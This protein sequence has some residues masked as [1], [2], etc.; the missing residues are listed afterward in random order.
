MELLYIP[1]THD[2]PEIKFDS[3]TGKFSII[4]RSYPSDT[5]TFY[6]PVNT[7]LNKYALNPNKTIIFEINVEYF[8]SVSVKFLTNII[9]K[10]ISLNSADISVS[11]V[12]YYE[13]DDDDN[14]DLGR[15]IERDTHFKFTYVI[16]EEETE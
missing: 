2:T 12:W 16:L 8:H 15:S 1:G 4:G 13:E 7:W 6:Q 10:L 9:K 11:I 5:P 14:I 3:I